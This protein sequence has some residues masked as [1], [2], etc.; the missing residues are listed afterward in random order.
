MV[1]VGI[2]AS[3][4]PVP[5]NG[6]TILF[7]DSSDDQYKLK[8]HTGEVIRIDEISQAVDALQMFV[9]SETMHPDE[10]E[11]KYYPFADPKSILTKAKEALQKIKS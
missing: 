8:L 1:I 3:E 11:K 9:D 7:L 4:V 10:Y 6:K 2:K 5:L